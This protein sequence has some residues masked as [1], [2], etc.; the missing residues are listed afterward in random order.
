M[1]SAWRREAL[2][3]AGAGL[4]AT[5]FCG[6]LL[7]RDPRLCWKD[8]F[9]ISIL[10]VFADAARAW[11]AGEWPLLSGGSWV[12]GNLAGE[13][14]YGTFSP[15]VNAAA[16]LADAL[17]VP[18]PG[19]A[20]A[21]ALPHVALFAA[22]AY[23]LARRR[24]VR[25]ALAA[26]VA[27]VG[28]LNGWNVT[29]GIT[30]WFGALAA[31]AWLPWCWWAFEGALQPGETRFSRRLLWPAATV[32]GLLTGGF[33]YTVGMLGLVSAWLGVRTWAQGGVTGLDFRGRARTLWPLGAGWALGGLLAAPAWL[34]LLAHM[35]G[36]DRAR[37]AHVLASAWVVPW[38]A[39]PGLVVPSWKVPWA[40]FGENL[41]PRPAP[42]LAGGLVPLALLL[43]AGLRTGGGSAA[44]RSRWELGLTGAALALCLLPSAGLF[45]WSFRWL[46]T[47]HLALALTAGRAATTSAGDVNN[48]GP[49]P[50][51]W[52]AGLAALAWRGGNHDGGTTLAKQTCALGL[53]WAAAARVLPAAARPWCPALAALGSLWL[54]Y[55]AL[56]TNPGVPHYPFT[57]NLRVPGPL[58]PGRLYLS[59][60]REP[61]FYHTVAANAP[62]G[63]GA[64]V[65]PGSTPL[66]APG[67]RFVNGYSPI[68][69]AGVGRRLEMETH[70]FIPEPVVRQLAAEELGPDGLLA[71][72]GVDGLIVAADHPVAVQPSAEIW[73]MVH[74]DAEARVYHRRG[75]P[76]P[77]VRVLTI[78]AGAGGTATR[79]TAP[80]TTAA[81]SVAV[82]RENGRQRVIVDVVTAMPPSPTGGKE[83]VVVV[84]RRPFFPGWRA[85]LDGR[86]LPV[87][88]WE[89]GLC[90][91]VVLPAGSRGQLTLSYRP[92]AVTVGTALALV[93]AATLAAA[94]WLWRCRSR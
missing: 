39:L 71:R 8:D 44:W 56:S 28:T 45:R 20:A 23:L 58:A 75:A 78:A 81:A 35:A 18:L 53:A 41:R 31:N 59:L 47:F 51:A 29:W 3:A 82:V 73:E 48:D 87:Q 85:A 2:G 4:L 34:S 74:A 11:W 46:P 38:R 5:G 80:L 40:D 84:F 33:P 70:G 67:L 93:G 52:A 90:P 19:K 10:P 88:P 24:R 49:R 94:G 22:G 27:A 60:H 89:D 43:A 14:Q 63:F 7:R 65:R 26:M 16:L 13:Y 86:A 92:R 30:N 15:A 66:F 83:T 76:A 36:S 79:A 12:C 57:D 32:F 25:P 61:F 62:V 69:A 54:A 17:P 72:L 1:S 21:L 55:R 6:A 42:E 50:G 91:A 68:M 64:T 77:N 9:A 37:G